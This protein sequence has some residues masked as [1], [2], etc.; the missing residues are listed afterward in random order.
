MNFFLRNWLLMIKFLIISLKY[1]HKY[2][3]SLYT[4]YFAYLYPIFCI[5]IQLLQKKSIQANFESMPCGPQIQGLALWNLVQKGAG[6][7]A[8]FYFLCMYLTILNIRIIPRE[9]VLKAT[10]LI[11]S[12]SLLQRRYNSTGWW[13]YFPQLDIFGSYQQ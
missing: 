6:P 8:Q 9:I 10:Q 7:G 3:Y 12:D 4:L 13:S 11:P 2:M 1:S 5:K